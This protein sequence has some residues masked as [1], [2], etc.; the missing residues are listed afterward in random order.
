MNRRRINQ[1]TDF[2]LNKGGLRSSLQPKEFISTSLNQD[3]NMN[4]VATPFGFNPIKV[5]KLQ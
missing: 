5:K 4:K 2:S 3:T 1:S